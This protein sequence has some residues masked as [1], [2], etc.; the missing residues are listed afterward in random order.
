MEYVDSIM[1]DV[2]WL[3][4][5][6]DDRFYH[7]SD[8]FEQLYEWAIDLIKAGNAFVDSSSA[9]EI[10]QY[11]GTLTEPGKDSPYRNRPV[12]EN[13]DLFQ[14]MRAGEFKDGEHVLRA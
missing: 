6:W 2:R 7:A 12:A 11:R 4:F 13:L 1:N 3:G 9:D 14:R 5:D 8:Y 10:R